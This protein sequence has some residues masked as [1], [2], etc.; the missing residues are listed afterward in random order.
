MLA[1]EGFEPA[2]I[3]EILNVSSSEVVELIDT[4]D[5]EISRQV[6]G[7]KVLVIEDEPITAMYLQDLVTDLGH[8]VAGIA[9]THREAIHLTEIERVDLILSDIELADGSSGITAVNEILNRVRVP[10]IFITGHPELLL[11]G[12]KPEPAFLI[13]KPF[14]PRTVQA[15]LGQALLFDVHSNPSEVTAAYH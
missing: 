13:S 12:E 3:A 1:V 14:V 6:K 15:V 11:T 9:R 10:V 8:K 5:K 7:A 4:A 2:A